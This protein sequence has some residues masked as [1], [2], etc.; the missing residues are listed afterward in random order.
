LSPI[1]LLIQLSVAGCGPTLPPPTTAPAPSPTTAAAEPTATARVATPPRE[2]YPGWASYANDRYGFSFQYPASWS[3]QEIP[4]DGVLA[5]SVV[6]RWETAR[7]VIQYKR[8]T[9]DAIIEENPAAREWE[10]QGSVTFL[11]QELS[12]RVRSL[13]NRVKRVT[14]WLPQRPIEAGELTFNIELQSIATS[15]CKAQFNTDCAFGAIN[16]PPSLQAEA[17][18]IVES[19]ERIPV[20]LSEKEAPYPGWIRYVRVDYGFSF[21]YPPTWTLVEGRNFIDLRQQ[22]LHL[23]IGYR[24]AEESLNISGQAETQP[25]DMVSAGTVPFLGQQVPKAVLRYQGKAKA[26]IYNSGDRISI[27]DRVFLLNLEDFAPDYEAVDLPEAVQAEAD[28]IIGSLVTFE[29]PVDVTPTPPPTRLPPTP[30]VPLVVAGTDG[31]NVRS[32]PRIEERTRIGYLAPGTNATVIGRHGNWWQ[33]EYEGAPAWVFADV[34]EA[35]N[36]GN[37]SQVELTLAATGPPTPMPPAPTPGQPAIVAGGDGANLRSGPGTDHPRIGYLDPGAQARVT[38]R[39]GDWWQIEHD[40]SPLWVSGQVVIAY[41]VETVPEI[42]PAPTPTP[43]PS[44]LPEL[45]AGL[46]EERWIDIDLNHQRVTAYEGR[47]AVYTTLASTG[48]PNTPTPP[49]QF[50]IWIKLRYD[51]M[52]GPGYYLED[53]PYVMYFYQ[54]YGLHGVWWHANFGH[55]M[56][57]GCVNLPAE[58]A[59]W[60]F[61]WADVGTLVNVHH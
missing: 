2:T 29:S 52:A 17:D 25:G 30:T 42:T 49:G 48:L 11:G 22:R 28:R 20:A 50:R 31:A 7:L 34:V 54:G 39:S 3:L 4:S 24:D 15:E 12:R 9:E 19:F 40:G 38:G 13:D 23:L 41:H 33:I 53:V 18:R 16:I 51:D 37:V 61:T 27:G 10:A 59:E 1:L 55:P 21:R 14:Y 35:L 58:A 57:H 56:S 5:S 60:L 36:L 46:Y 32:E 44:P 47:T 45:P 26:V 43:T 8:S 6:L